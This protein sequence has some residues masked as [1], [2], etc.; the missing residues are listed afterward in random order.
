[1]T[2]SYLKK[3]FSFLPLIFFLTLCT[4]LLIVFVKLSLWQVQ[5]LSWKKNLISQ[6]QTR[7]HEPKK[8]LPSKKIWKNMT[9]EGYEYLPVKTKGY[10]LP[11]QQIFVTAM[12]EDSTG[13]WWLMPLKTRDGNIVFVNRGFLTQDQRESVKSLRPAKK[14]LMISGLLRMSEK[15][16]TL[17]Q[18]NN[19][20]KNLWY[21]RNIPQ[22]TQILKINPAIVAPYFI[23]A[24]HIEKQNIGILGLTKINFPNNHLSYA[25]TWSILAL[26]MLCIIIYTLYDAFKKNHKSTTIR[27]Y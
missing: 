6:V 17:F 27:R 18:K 10:F 12:N 5:R 7:I 24:F 22:M 23:D 1:M 19:P 20:Q 9:Q 2:Y 4:A 11:D 26:F 14:T 13:F 8:N 21:H 3:I 25:I 16:E 15:K